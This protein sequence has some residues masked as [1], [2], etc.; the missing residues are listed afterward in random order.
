MGLKR[1]IV[2]AAAVLALSGPSGG[3]WARDPVP[4]QTLA[5][6]PEI[7]SV[8]MSSDGRTIVAVLGK[9]GAE[10]FETLLASWDLDN[11]EKGPTVTASGD[12]MKFVSAA[13]LKAGRSSSRATGMDRG[14]GR[15]R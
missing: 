10:E 13:A 11:L 2:A 12:R 5:G 1:M 4:V 3:A 8:S 14:A 9:P 7:Q 6:M 15:L